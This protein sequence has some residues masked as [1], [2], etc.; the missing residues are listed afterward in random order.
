MTLRGR[1]ASIEDDDDLAGIDRLSRH[2]LGAAYG[3]REQAR[4]DAWIEVDRWHA[5]VHGRPWR[6]ASW[7]RVARSGPWT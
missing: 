4:V 3:H 2:Y 1:V 6:P 7:S 5:W